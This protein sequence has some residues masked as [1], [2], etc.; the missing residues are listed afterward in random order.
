MKNI[1]EY[2]VQKDTTLIEGLKN[3]N[4][5]T[6]GILLILDKKKLVGILTDGDYRRLL[7]NNINFED[8]VID[9]ANKNFV[10]SDNDEA[11]NQ[12]LSKLSNSIK[13]LPVL[14]KN[15]E[16]L[17]LLTLNDLL[18][19]PISNPEISENEKKYV[20]D[21]LNSGWISSQGSYVKAF[22][23]ELIDYLSQGKNDIYLTTTSSGTAALELVF[24]SLDIGVGDEVI[25]PSVTFG[26]TANSIINCGATPVFVDVSLETFNIDTTSIQKYINEK[27]K[28][29][30][31]V[32]L[33][34]NP[35]SAKP[36]ID[37]CKKN[38]LFLIEDAAEAIGSKYKNN[39]CGTIGDAGTL[40][41]FANKLI[42]TGEGGAAIFKHKKHYE[43]SLSIKNHGM[44][45]DR[46]YWHNSVGSNYRLTNLQAALGL[47]QIEKIDYFLDSRNE[48]YEIYDSFFRESKDFI[49][50]KLENSSI[51]SYWL[52]PVLCNPV[53]PQIFEKLYSHLEKDSIET[54]PVFPPL[55][56]QK[57]FST[58]KRCEL[59]IAEKYFLKGLCL[60]VSNN[61]SDD[62]KNRIKNS[63]ESFFK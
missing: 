55:H 53:N 30:V 52:Y 37:I 12:K 47:A 15:G 7:L 22:E 10:F 34:G 18:L 31:V 63:L 51:S 24:K 62:E 3:I 19:V 44:D 50:P 33:Y 2:T 57:A 45:K 42:T 58:Y 6:E 26:A 61:M 5:G 59:P 29:I 8:K 36:I 16:I 9:H 60:P 54:R 32:H 4:R 25:L 43:R 41:F 49:V 11:K 13:H 28:A 38:D 40:S 21:A 48:I 20:L 1:S 56:I 14:D 23:K 17:D 39:L 27:T 35:V 46:K